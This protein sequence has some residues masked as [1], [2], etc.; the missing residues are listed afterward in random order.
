M[1]EALLL[2]EV[3]AK[4]AQNFWPVLALG[5]VAWTVIRVQESK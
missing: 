5:A 4:V 3:L 2:L 1:K